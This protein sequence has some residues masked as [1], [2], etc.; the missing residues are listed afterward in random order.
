MRKPHPPHPPKPG[1]VSEEKFVEFFFVLQMSVFGGNLGG[2][3]FLARLSPNLLK[4][5][6]GLENPSKCL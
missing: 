4:S 5:E 2:G 6:L 3:F 1:R